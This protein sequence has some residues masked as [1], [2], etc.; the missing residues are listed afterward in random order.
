[1]NLQILGNAIPHLHCHLVPRY[2]GDPAPS[3]PIDPETGELHLSL[4]E[5]QQRAD[6]IRNALR[7]E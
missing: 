3:R 6:A 1:M 4:N 5:S 2:Y 7:W